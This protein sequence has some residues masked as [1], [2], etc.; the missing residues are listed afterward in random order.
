[1]MIPLIC[2]LVCMLPEL[3]SSIVWTGAIE[4]A[5]AVVQL[6]AHSVM[7]PSL[8]VDAAPA[9]L[10]GVMLPA[11]PSGLKPNILF[12]KDGGG[13]AGNNGTP[14]GDAGGGGGD[15]G[16]PGGGG[17][18]GSSG[19]GG[20]EPPSRSEMD[21]LVSLTDSSLEDPEGGDPG[22]D[23]KTGKKPGDGSESAE[24]PSGESGE[25]DDPDKKGD[26]TDDDP[27]KKGDTPGD[28]EQV[29]Y[30]EGFE[31]DLVDVDGKKRFYHASV[32]G[33]DTG[34]GTSYPSR[35]DAELGWTNKVKHIQ[36]QI[37]KLKELNKDVGAVDLPEWL[38]DPE[39]EETYQKLM[40]VD[41]PMELKNEELRDHIKQADQLITH[42]NNRTE[43]L[44]EKATQTE[45]RQKLEQQRDEVLDKTAEVVQDL[46]IPIDQIPRFQ[47]QKKQD[48]AIRS[49]V[50]KA[51]NKKI[52]EDLK[53][54]ADE[55]KEL[56]NDRDKAADDENYGD[57][58]EAKFKELETKRGE[59]QK[60]YQEQFL[61]PFDKVGELR[62]QWQALET[63]ADPQVTEKQR[64][65][66]RSTAFQDL[67][68]ELQDKHPIFMASDRRGVDS[69]FNWMMTRADQFNG[70]LTTYDQ[71]RALRAWDK[72]I[73]ERRAEIRGKKVQEKNNQGKK[74]GDDMP[75][76]GDQKE[77]RDPAHSRQLS[78][79][80]RGKKELNDL[81]KE[82]DQRVAG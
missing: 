47:D 76:Y 79:R 51:V 65:E 1:M 8:Y 81:A 82:T 5:E 9:I 69:F 68:Q 45:Q 25:D 29:Q 24:K 21:E 80:E 49:E 67:Q 71:H 55:Y 43:R 48:E 26:E 53:P 20:A 16:E 57:K 61:Q 75:G 46:Q 78:D 34:Q 56:K 12:E 58:L 10:A 2:T 37:G 30:R 7:N 17:D 50:S 22:S 11:V 44:S 64:A 19:D 32:H 39:G 74:P 36:N 63:K 42:L 33:K 35:D 52:A 62:E 70:A 23:D 40:D 15:D 59:L 27:D 4:S 18:P 13:A 38:S 28:D 6:T 41:Y 66:Q 60:K 73:A 3:F 14:S 31:E 72:H 54:L 77:I